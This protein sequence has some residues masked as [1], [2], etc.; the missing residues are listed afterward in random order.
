MV[1]DSVNDSLLLGGIIR[2]RFYGF[3]EVVSY[4]VGERVFDGLGV[5]FIVLCLDP[6]GIFHVVDAVA[7]LVE[8]GLEGAMGMI[9]CHTVRNRKV[10]STSLPT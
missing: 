4:I 8:E 5:I 7:Y 3:C 9:D 2:M 10:P 6:K 1:H